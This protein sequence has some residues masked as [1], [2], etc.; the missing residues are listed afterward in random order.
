MEKE[1]LKINILA[2]AGAGLL[3]LVTGILLYAVRGSVGTHIRFFLPIPPLGVAAYVLAFNVFRHYNGRLPGGPGVVLTE[4]AW[5]TAIAAAVFSLFSL[6][7]LVGIKL[8]QREL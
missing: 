6:I 3:M 2:I 1:L 5:G 8:F 4:V 7:L